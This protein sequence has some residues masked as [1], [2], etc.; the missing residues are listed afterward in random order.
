MMKEYV[1]AIDQGKIVH[2]IPMWRF[3]ENECTQV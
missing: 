2:Y 3:A 1:S